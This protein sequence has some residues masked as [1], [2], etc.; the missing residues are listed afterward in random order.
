MVA[1]PFLR[2]IEWPDKGR[3]AIPRRVVPRHQHAVTVGEA[4][5]GR[6]AEDLPSVAAGGCPEEHPPANCVW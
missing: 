4:F 5:L 1:R 3:V 2:N 6:L